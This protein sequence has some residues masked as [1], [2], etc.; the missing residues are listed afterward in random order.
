MSIQRPYEKSVSDDPFAAFLAMQAGSAAGPSSS[1]SQGDN[2]DVPVI[3]RNETTY[4]DPT[5]GRG[6]PNRYRNAFLARDTSGPVTSVSDMKRVAGLPS[7]AFYTGPD[8]EYRANRKQARGPAEIAA[9]DAELERLASRIAEAPEPWKGPKP[10]EAMREQPRV[11]QSR[12]ESKPYVGDVPI[13]DMFEHPLTKGTSRYATRSRE[14][15]QAEETLLAARRAARR[16]QAALKLRQEEELLLNVG[17]GSSRRFED[18]PRMDAMEAPPE[19]L[20]YNPG[21]KRPWPLISQKT[22]CA[23]MGLTHLNDETRTSIDADIYGCKHSSS[24]LAES[25]K[26]EAAHY[27]AVVHRACFYLTGRPLPWIPTV[28]PLSLVRRTSARYATMFKDEN[29]YA[30]L[31]LL[32]QTRLTAVRLVGL[33]HRLDP[34]WAHPEDGTRDFG[35]FRE[36]RRRTSMSLDQ[37]RLEMGF[38]LF[39]YMGPRET[40]DILSVACHLEGGSYPIIAVPLM[41]AIAKVSATSC[42]LLT[43]IVVNLKELRSDPADEVITRPELHDPDDWCRELI[44]HSYFFSLFDASAFTRMAE[45]TTEDARY[46]E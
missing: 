4:V 31:T 36:A 40:K 24:G 25:L 16:A 2:L 20:M 43:L 14:E 21:T 1:T 34:Y 29:V 15:V 5:S 19:A 35:A 26:D 30:D 28:D 6:N 7:H 38:H 44:L 37:W 27:F 18:G 11:T 23:M 42:V 12:K 10:K 17:H 33:K 22:L 32:L 45:P 8:E 41:F 3:A 9:R 39:K 46:L 13:E